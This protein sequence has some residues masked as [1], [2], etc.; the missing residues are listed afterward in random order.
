[1]KLF[2]EVRTVALSFGVAFIFIGA[3]NERVFGYS[4]IKVAESTGSQVAYSLKLYAFAL[5]SWKA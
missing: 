4:C 3:F 5:R 1:M 2:G